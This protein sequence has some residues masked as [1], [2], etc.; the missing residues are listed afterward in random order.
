[1]AGVYGGYFGAAQGVL[2]MGIM[3]VG[4]AETLQRL[5]ALKNVLAA[6]VNAVAGLLF[7]LVADVDWRIVALIGVGSVIGGQLGATVGRRLPSGVL[8]AVIVV[9]GVAALVVFL[10]QLTFAA[11]R[12]PRAARSPAMPESTAPT[13]GP[14]SMAP[15]RT[16]TVLSRIPSTPVTASARSTP[17]PASTRLRRVDPRASRVAAPSAISREP[18]SRART[19]PCG[20]FSMFRPSMPAARS[21]L[22]EGD[23]ADRDAAKGESDHGVH[24]VETRAMELYDVMRTTAAIREFTDDPLP[25]DVLARILDNARFA[26]SG[27]N[28]QGAHLVLVTE[29]ATREAL[30]ELYKPAVRRYAA[31]SAA[32]ETPW[33]P[34]RPPGPSAEEIAA[35]EVPSYFV[36]PVFTAAVVVVV[37]VDLGMVAATDQDLDRVGVV[38][39]ASVYPLVW[40]MLLAARNEGFGGTITTMAVAQE[41]AVRSSSASPSSTPSPPWCRSASRSSSPRSCA[42]SRW[43]SS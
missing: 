39:G 10:R 15:A 30:A 34:L 35:T 9:V 42:G 18:K 6:I 23:D 24:A 7:A 12:Q 16:G 28:R 13:A 5:N 22:G 36:T 37:C 21:G 31:Q 19:G 41:P 11:E 3:G 4:I 43:R 32:G 2:L 40:N 25:D 14:V 38:S 20:L 1:M 17:M 27:G 8:R 26:P 29:Q 33:N